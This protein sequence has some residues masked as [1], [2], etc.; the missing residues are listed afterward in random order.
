M[1]YPSFEVLYQNLYDPN[2]LE[3]PVSIAAS[4]EPDTMHFHKAMKQP[5]KYKSIEAMQKRLMT[6]AHKINEKSSGNLK[7]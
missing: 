4:S 3:N 6:T 2:E 1:F 7:Y 5:E